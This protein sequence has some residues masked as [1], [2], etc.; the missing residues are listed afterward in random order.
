M[1]DIAI[2]VLGSTAVS[3][4]VTWVLTQIS[5]GLEC[6]DTLA[7]LARRMD[8]AEK[9]SVRLQMLVLMSDYPDNRDEIMEVAQ[10][11]FHDLGG[12]WYMTAMFN[13]WLERENVGRPEWFKSK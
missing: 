1:T 6:R 13:A 9:D 7:T 12:N 4:V 10:H 11:Y 5:K 3:S 2:A 8:K